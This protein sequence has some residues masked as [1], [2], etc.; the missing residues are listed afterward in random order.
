VASASSTILVTWPDYDMDDPL[1]GIEALQV[2]VLAGAALDVFDVEPPPIDSPL[3]TMN[4][5][6]LS[7]H[8]AGI[9]TV[10]IAEMTRRATQAV[11]DVAAGRRITHLVNPE[12][13]E[14]AP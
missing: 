8:V 14:A 2:G 12:S 7:P 9:C 3:L 4:N 6:V 10:S 5:V 11:I 1:L 13:L